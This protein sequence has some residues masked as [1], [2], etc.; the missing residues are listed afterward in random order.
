MTSRLQRYPLDLETARALGKSLSM[1]NGRGRGVARCR[2][3]PERNPNRP[4]KRRFSRAID[5]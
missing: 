5:I 1:R 4:L 3:L 2:R